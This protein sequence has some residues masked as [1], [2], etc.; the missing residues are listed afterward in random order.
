MEWE[1]GFYRGPTCHYKSIRPSAKIKVQR[2]E[3]TSPFVHSIRSKQQSD[4]TSLMSIH[5]VEIR[6]SIILKWAPSYQK[7]KKNLHKNTVVLLP[8]FQIKTKRS[9]GDWWGLE[10]NFWLVGGLNHV[11]SWHMFGVTQINGTL[12]VTYVNRKLV[13]YVAEVRA[14]NG[15]GGASPSPACKCKVAEDNWIPTAK[16]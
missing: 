6:T 14:F 5:W 12:T 11:G 3:R 2:L 8:H 15:V 4:Q 7:R 16:V 9:T 13:R 1:K 10:R